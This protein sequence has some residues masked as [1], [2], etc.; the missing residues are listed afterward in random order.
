MTHAS[1]FQS[2]IEEQFNDEPG[3]MARFVVSRGAS[4]TGWEANAMND[5]LVDIAANNELA[6]D[7]TFLAWLRTALASIGLGVVVAKVAFI[8]NEGHQPLHGQALYSAVGIS[9]V[10]C[11]GLGRVLSAPK[12]GTKP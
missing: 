6:N 11:G 12:G 4:G 2:A 10:V 8:V 7:R 1:L 5:E 9:F 3:P